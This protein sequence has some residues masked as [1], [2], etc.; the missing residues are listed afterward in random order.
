M[1][2]D[3]KV[4]DIMVEDVAYVTV[5]G[6]RDE[7]MAICRS[8]YISGAPVV[9]DGRVVGIV[10]RQDLLKNPNEEQIALL[11]T[12]NPITIGPDA[13]M[14][15]AAKLMLSNKIRRL[16]VVMGDK[17]VGIIS[18][19]DI[20]R[21]IADLDITEPISNYIGDDTVAVW[22]ETPLPVVGR[23][24]E[25]AGVKAAPILNTELDLVGL[26][27]DRDLINAA[28]I[29]DRT[30]NSDLSLGSDEDKWSWEGMRDT[31]KLYYSISKI[32]L[33]DRLVKE[34]MVKDPVTATRNSQVSECARVMSENKFDQLPVVSARGKLV[35]LLFDR[36]L[37]KVL[38]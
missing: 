32:S 24:M 18:V 25:L 35:G 20:V 22:D 26:I 6:T 4:R 30:M 9:K 34:V 16:P 27:T 28:V 14:N 12:R 37:L 5:P 7:L 33:P 2:K 36:N 31:M 11:M 17:L 15:E 10:T 3:I 29:E 8:R 1:K 19:A 13:S 21:A 23:I 38:V